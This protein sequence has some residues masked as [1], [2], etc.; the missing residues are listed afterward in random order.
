MR[1]LV[2]GRDGQV[3][4]SLLAA[5]QAAGHEVVALAR[6]A[7]DLAGPE[8]AIV[9][10]IAAARP[11]LIVSAAAY[12]A[13]DRAEEERELAFAINARGAGFVAKAARQVGVPLLHLSTDYVFDGRKSA[14]YS[15]E[16]APAPTGVYGA[17]KVAGEE[18]VL[19]AHHDSVVLRTAWVYSPFGRNFVKTM[20]T[21]A[22]SRPE[23]RVV[24]DQ[25]GN[26]TSARDIAEALLTIANNVRASE[27]AS[28]RG[29]FHLT[30]PDSASWADFADHVFGA[31]KEA[32]G[33]WATVARITTEE[34]PTP[35]RRPANSRLDCSRLA[36][37]HGLVL[38][39]WRS[40]ATRVV[41]EL[42]NRQ[43]EGNRS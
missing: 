18:A 16:D 29:L 40:S 31:S 26:P 20:L 23:V 8:E 12:T 42:I 2:T 9:S 33:P 10:A 3:A 21:L 43:H 1:I 39:S 35:T 24:A 27:R 38:P 4:R 6:P 7:L 25:I 19:A 34:F 32:G 14:P 28:L 41:A 11:D 17:S 37:E 30:A 15:E 13:V 36:R 5:G 22:E